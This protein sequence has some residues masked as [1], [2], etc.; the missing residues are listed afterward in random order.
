MRR[1]FIFDDPDNN[2]FGCAPTNPRGL[3]VEFDE[4]DAGVEIEYTVPA[5]LCGA[6]GVVHGGIQATILD[7]AMCVTAFAK[8]GHQVVTGELRLRYNKPIPTGVALVAQGRIRETKGN[9]AFIEGRLFVAGED[10]ERTRAEGRF[11]RLDR[12]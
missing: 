10:E 8:L 7:E 9:S 5:E 4:T 12:E 11:F 3:H 2:C 1:H 6:P